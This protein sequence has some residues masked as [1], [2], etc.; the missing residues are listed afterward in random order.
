MEDFNTE[1]EPFGIWSLYGLKGNPFST[2]ALPT[3]GGELTIDNFYGREKETKIVE[4]IIYNNLQSRMLINGAIGIG[5]TTFVN[6][7]RAQSFEKGYFTTIAEIGIQHEWEAQEFMKVTLSSIYTSINRIKGVRQKFDKEFLDKL[8]IYF[9]MIRGRSGGI[10]GGAAG[11]SLGKDKGVDYDVPEL[12]SFMMKDLLV[13]IVENLRKAGYKGLIIHYNNLEF[14]SEKEDKTLIKLFN[15]IRDFL[16][17]ERVHFI[18]VGD[19]TVSDVLQKVPRADDI[20]FPPIHLEPFSYKEVC[21]VIDRRVEFLRI[22]NITVDKPF[23]NEAIEI[24]YKLFSGN[25]RA[26]FKSLTTAIT[27]L[28]VDNKPIIIYPRNMAIVLKKIAEDKYL[29]NLNQ[30]EMKI[31]EQIIKRK[32]T[33]NKLISEALKLKPQNISNGITTL[34]NYNC[35][36]LS[37]VEG[38]A[39][40]YVPAPE[41]RWLFFNV[42]SNE[43]LGVQSRLKIPLD[44][45]VG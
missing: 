35:I 36:R 13:E 6:Y 40:Y 24:L 12:D 25:I 20:F 10:S 21:S 9:G 30:T 18:F 33:T 7:I 17:I 42:A 4:D 31:L 32:E 11:F 43:E 44:E 14:L 29:S 15:G 19:L 16:Q 38:R 39:R 34:R 37:R 5:K 23:T 1:S 45:Q 26:I 3:F 22:R 8:D 2:E 41:I 27:A 28:A